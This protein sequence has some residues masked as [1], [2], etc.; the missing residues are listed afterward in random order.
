M[1]TNVTVDYKK[2]E[3]DFRKARDPRERLECLREMMRTIPKHKGT[4][5]L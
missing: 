4:E 1:P 5:H 2:A 3:D